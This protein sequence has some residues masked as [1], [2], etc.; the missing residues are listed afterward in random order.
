MRRQ[1][2]G[3]AAATMVLLAGCGDKGG[4]DTTGPATEKFSATMSG[5]SV[6]PAVTTTS[7]G[8]VA[9]EVVGDSLLT[10][11]LTV[12]GMT[13]L[14]QAHLHNAATG[15][16]ATPLVWLLP[17]NGTAAQQPSVQLTGVIATGDIAPSWV[18]GTPRLAMDSVK[19]LLRLGRLYVD[20]HSAA[21]PNGEIRG[22]V[23]RVP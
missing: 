14:T 23:A 20:V 4:S 22:Q 13:G 11:A 12:T 6:V 7:T 5:A 19:A 10:F 17:V 16:T 1:Y 3:L 9:F 21:F 2:A 8:S 15:T 18:R